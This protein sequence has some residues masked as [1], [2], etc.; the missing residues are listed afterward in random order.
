M[1]SFRATNDIVSPVKAV[2]WGLTE[3]SV[4]K[5]DS[6]EWIRDACFP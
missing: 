1:V 3:V 5:K 6:I 4:L 2:G